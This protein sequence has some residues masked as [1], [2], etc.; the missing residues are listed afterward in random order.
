MK[1]LQ[2]QEDTLGRQLKAT[3]KASSNYGKEI[4]GK[5][6]EPAK[7]GAKNVHTLDG[8][9]LSLDSLQQTCPKMATTGVEL[10]ASCLT[11]RQKEDVGLG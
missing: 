4:L 6:S 3:G 1:Q 5:Q 9:Q 11:L 7:I 2:Q 10:N 8:E